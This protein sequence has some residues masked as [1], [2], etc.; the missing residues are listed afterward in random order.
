[1]SVLEGTQAEPK[2]YRVKSFR[3][4]P[5]D[6]KGIG[7]TPLCEG[8][9]AIALG[10]PA[11]SHSPGC[12]HRV[13]EELYRQGDSRLERALIRMHA[14]DERKEKE[15]ETSGEGASGSM[16]RKKE[17]SKERKERKKA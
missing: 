4:S 3:I 7:F 12:R 1:M 14:E 2:E 15:K 13:Q 9:R 11:Q 10:L 8:C 16:K 17:R 5:R 6:F